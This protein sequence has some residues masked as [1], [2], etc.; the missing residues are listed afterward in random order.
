MYKIFI[1]L[2]E[3]QGTEILLL[4]SNHVLFTNKGI[5]V[6]NQGRINYDT[7]VNCTITGN[8]QEIF[9]VRNGEV[10]TKVEDVFESIMVSSDSY[11]TR[12]SA[13]EIMQEYNNSLGMLDMAKRNQKAFMKS[14]KENTEFLMK[15]ANNTEQ[16]AE[17][18]AK[19]EG[20]TE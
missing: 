9:K 1:E 18:V 5:V 17:L 20:F 4:E 14:V 12:Q 2:K 10:K 11:D 8:G 6:D 19:A 16:M 7:I 13:I 15:N 3:E